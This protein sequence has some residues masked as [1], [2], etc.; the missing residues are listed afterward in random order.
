MENV[1]K[2]RRL[3]VNHHHPQYCELY[4]ILKI[5]A[6]LDFRGC[7]FRDSWFTPIYNSI[8]F[9]SPLVLL[10]INLDLRGFCFRCFFL[11]P[12]INSVNQRMPVIFLQIYTTKL[13]LSLLK[14]I[15]CTIH[16]ICDSLFEFHIWIF[17]KA[18]LA[19]LK[20][21]CSAQTHKTFICIVWKLQIFSYF[22]V[23]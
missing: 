6:F 10:S 13:F 11:C 2:M 18:I 19:L 8:L 3:T 9:S 17:F 16:C 20:M 14:L 21:A 7:D 5:Q 15:P 4:K 12:C 23:A 1:T 22:L